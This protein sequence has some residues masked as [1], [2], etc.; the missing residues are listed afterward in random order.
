MSVAK[1]ARLLEYRPRFT[2]LQAVMESVAWLIDQGLVEGTPL[3]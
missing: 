1:A 2:S 3:S